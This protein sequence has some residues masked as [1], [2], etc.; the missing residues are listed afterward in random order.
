M[1]FLPRVARFTAALLTIALAACGGG[2]GGS[3]QPQT[4]AGPTITGTAATGSPLEGATIVVYSKGTAIATLANAVSSTGTYSITLPAGSTGPFIIAAIRDDIRL[5]GVR[6]SSTGGVANVTPITSLILA[7]LASNGDPAQ[8]IADVV[9]NPSAASDTAV[10]ARKAEIATMLQSILQATGQTSFDPVSGN[11][12]ADGSGY[13]RMLDSLLVTITPSG[14]TSNINI[15]VK[16]E[17]DTAALAFGSGETTP[18]PLPQV[19][20]NL[21]PA[22]GMPQKI[23]TLMQGLTACYQLPKTQRVSGDNVTA[24]ACTSLFYDND[25]ST[26]LSGGQTVGPG[27]AFASLYSDSATGAVFGP[28]NYEFTRGNGDVVLSY[29]VV[30]ASGNVDFNSVVVTEQNGAFKLHGNQYQYPGSVVPYSQFREFPA[31]PEASYYSTGFDLRV[32]NITDNSGNPI[33]HKVVVTS[34]RG[35]KITLVPASG[36]NSLEITKSFPTPTRTSFVR[37]RAEWADPATTAQNVYPDAYEHSLFFAP[38]GTYDDT[39][40]AGIS[41]QSVWTFEYWLAANQTD[42]PDAVQ[43]YRTLSRPLTIAELKAVTLPSAAPATISSLA[44]QITPTP[45]KKAVPLDQAGNSTFAWLV[46]PG[47]IPPYNVK[48]WGFYGNVS[49]FNDQTGVA[50]SQRNA[51][52]PC[53]QQTQADAHCNGSAFAT[54]DY[55]DAFHLLTKSARLRETSHFYSLYTLGL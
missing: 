6:T 44:N 18:P 19:S 17:D 37:L 42:T 33:F 46:P 53:T 29:R 1:A 26:Y 12:S 21:L 34:P 55:M 23:R 3:S 15:T 41:N 43:A 8:L 25:P 16:G 28:A 11:F 20:T 40:I 51:T 35:N 2:S 38:K 9:S 52:I 4:G 31:Q 45:V 47:A 22:G 48:L 13:D 54:G 36:D 14:N 50:S 27:G 39:F 24:Q 49:F 32:A 10:N 5:Y 30:S 7:R